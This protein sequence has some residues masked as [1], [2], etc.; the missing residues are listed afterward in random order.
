MNS[1]EEAANCFRLDMDDER[2]RPVPGL[3]L[4]A[5]L[6]NVVGAVGGRGRAA[7]AAVWGLDGPADD[8]GGDVYVS[9]A[10]ENSYNLLAM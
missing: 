6:F 7:E 4:A 5:L 9:I 1:V 8:M 3:P 2:G 10:S